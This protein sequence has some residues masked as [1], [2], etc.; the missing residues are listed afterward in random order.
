MKTLNMAL[1]CC[2]VGFSEVII[3]VFHMKKKLTP[4][5]TKIPKFFIFQSSY[6]FFVKFLTYFV[7]WNV[8]KGQQRKSVLSSRLFRKVSCS[9][10]IGNV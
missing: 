9:I 7:D 4:K 2:P 1:V 6:A 3:A 10:R 5:V 8:E